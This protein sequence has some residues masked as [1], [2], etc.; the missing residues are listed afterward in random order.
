MK[1]CCF[2]GHATLYDDEE[3]IKSKLKNE[4]INL[5][6][7]ENVTTFY[8][9]GRGAFDRLCAI[10]LKELKKDYP[11]IK[12][13]LILAYMPKG[14]GSTESQLYDEIFDS[15]IYP[16]IENVTKRFV[17]LKRN[18]CMLDKSDFLIAYVKY[19][20]G[21]LKTLEYAEKRKNVKI[22]NVAKLI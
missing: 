6:E 22:I 7:K 16:N 15:N 3:I 5:I 18:K 8:S 9:G 2:A 1:T 14:R 10:T 21:A 12:S 11:L 19:T 4:I 20:G 13:Y 17:I